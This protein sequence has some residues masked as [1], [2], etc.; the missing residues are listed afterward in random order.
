MKKTKNETQTE[1]KNE[2]K[3]ETA[4]EMAKRLEKEVE[5]YKKEIEKLKTAEELDEKEKEILAEMDK[6][7]AYLKE[8]KYALPATCVYEGHTYS[9]S[10]IAKRIVR[11]IS[12]IEQTW[13]Y[14]LGLYELCKLWLDPAI[15]EIN[16]G[17]LDS[18]LRLLDQV[19][20]KGMLEW[21]DILA[22]NEFMKPLHEDYSK[23]VTMQI[24]LSQKHNEILKRRDLIQP[25]SG[26][27]KD[28][29]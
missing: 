2:N 14:V 5:A 20:F 8:R 7:D 26:P 11:F 3:N 1:T 17:A 19:K 13:Q 18:T 21:K 24:A 9:R 23:D 16:Y 12:K 4:L 25:V 10:E 27:A 29:E 6:Y 22:V 15:S 28:K